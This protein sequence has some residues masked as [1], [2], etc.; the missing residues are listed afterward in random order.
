MYKMEVKTNERILLITMSG[1]MTEKE[2]LA[3]IEEL[4]KNI[5]RINPTQ[6]SMVVDTRELKASPQNLINLMEQ[7]ME[8]ITTT[9]FKRRYSIMPKSAVATMQVKRVSKEDNK[10]NDTIFVEAYEDVLKAIA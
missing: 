6:Y 8:L 10:F 1:L 5:K 9:P 4:N 3:Y 2:S 7:A